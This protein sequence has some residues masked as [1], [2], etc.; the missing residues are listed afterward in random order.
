MSHGFDTS[1]FTLV[2]RPLLPEEAQQVSR[3]IRETPNIL[4]YSPR[5][6]L[7]FAS[8]LIMETTDGD[9]A[10]VCVTKHLSRSCSE[11]G[12]I[13]ILPL[14]RRQGIGSALFHIALQR[15][16]EQRRTILC[17]SREPSILRLMEASGMRFLPEWRLPVAVHLAR[18]RHYSNA[19]RFCESFRKMPM[20]RNQPPFRCAIRNQ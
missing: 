1:R 18:M 14:Y 11:I 2:D 17:V 8:C 4:G 20:Y 9:L 3:A 10:G 5:E 12:F 7:S 15:L 19:Y 16:V 13:L 6:L